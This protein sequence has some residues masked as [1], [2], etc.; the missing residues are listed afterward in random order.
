MSLLFPVLGSLQVKAITNS[1]GSEEIDL[2]ITEVFSLD[3][4]TSVRYDRTFSLSQKQPISLIH[5]DCKAF[6]NTVRSVFVNVTLNGV[7]IS[8]V[9]EDSNRDY[10]SPHT[11][12]KGTTLTLQVDSSTPLYILSNTISIEITVQTTSYFGSVTG[13]FLV[14][15]AIFETFTPPSITASSQKVPVTLSASKGTWYIAPLTILKQRSLESEIFVDITEKTRLRFD[16]SISPTDIPLSLT[17]FMISTGLSSY[18]STDLAADHSIT[19]DAKQGDGFFLVFNFRPSTDL[20]TDTVE[21]NID[22]S[23]TAIPYIAP[24]NPSGAEDEIQ[25]ASIPISSLEVLRVLIIIV[26]LFI[27]YI[28]NTKSKPIKKEIAVKKTA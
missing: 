28:R 13:D 21:L 16:I 1:T 10:S 5:V 23:V 8:E 3:N 12:I 18:E 2:N 22:V 26:P 11:Y 4:T 15:N 20:T 25:I 24:N 19:M 7:K 17:S 27:F 6:E 14:E 9:F